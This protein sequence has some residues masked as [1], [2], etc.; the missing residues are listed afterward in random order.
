VLETDVTLKV[1]TGSFT[2]ELGKDD[3]V[4]LLLPA[5]DGETVSGHGQ[6]V[7]DTFGEAGYRADAV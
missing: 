5:R 1:E 6:M 4:T 2:I 3:E 7:V